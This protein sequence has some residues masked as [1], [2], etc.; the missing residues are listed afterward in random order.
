ML[1]KLKLVENNEDA[2]QI[3]FEDFW[4]VWPRRVAKKDAQKAWLRIPATAHHK[5]LRAV[6]A[7]KKTEQWSRDD[8]Q[9]I[10]YPAS[11][12]NG[13]R[14]EDEL[15]V[16]MEFEQCAWNR[17]GSRG[18][19]GRCEATGSGTKNGQPYCRKHMEVA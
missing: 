6:E 4:A 18:P 17:N 3:S 19:G 14:W 12:L 13:E 11:W 10:P 7:N 1:T 8:G 2:P 9:Y 16:A 5:I 15:G